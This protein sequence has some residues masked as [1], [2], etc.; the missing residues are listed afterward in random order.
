MTFPQGLVSPEPTRRGTESPSLTWKCLTPTPETDASDILIIP[1]DAL[2]PFSSSAIVPLNREF[3]I[4]RN[5]PYSTPAPLL[6]PLSRLIDLRD[7]VNAMLAVSEE[8]A[9][10]MRSH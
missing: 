10:S 2:P 5:H 4:K 7:L 8:S 6:S 3:R 9:M 1:I